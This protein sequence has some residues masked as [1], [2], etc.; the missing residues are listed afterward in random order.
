MDTNEWKE[1]S[2]LEKLFL[3]EMKYYF[4]NGQLII[5]NKEETRW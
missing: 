1:K 2:L 4:F 5:G 3:Y